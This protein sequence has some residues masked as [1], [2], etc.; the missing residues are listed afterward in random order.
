MSI[1]EQ[2]LELSQKLTPHE[3]SELLAR[4]SGSNSKTGPANPV[5]LRGAWKAFVPASIDLDA[6]LYE[7]RHEW[8]EELELYK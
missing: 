1:V 8:E 4:L 6:A 5:R 7:I 2:I 3:R